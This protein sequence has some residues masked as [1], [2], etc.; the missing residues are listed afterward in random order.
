MIGFDLKNFD[1]LFD[2]MYGSIIIELD[3]SASDKDLEG[4]DYIDLNYY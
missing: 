4:L 3:D 2:K 1:N